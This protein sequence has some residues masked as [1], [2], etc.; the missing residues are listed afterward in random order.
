MYNPVHSDIRCVSS[1]SYRRNM[2]CPAV[3]FVVV[4]ILVIYVTAHGY[5]TSRY[6][7]TFTGFITISVVVLTECVWTTS[8]FLHSVFTY[9]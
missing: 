6:V 5:F 3:T 7:V 1:Y 4:I 8:H 9:V 2:V